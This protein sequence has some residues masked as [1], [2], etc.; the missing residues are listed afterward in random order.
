MDG[1]LN[2]NIMKNMVIVTHI[3]C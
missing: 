1:S 3:F 2:N